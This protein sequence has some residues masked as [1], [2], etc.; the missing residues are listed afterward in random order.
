MK[1]T[2]SLILSSIVARR[3]KPYARDDELRHIVGRV[4]RFQLIPRFYDGIDSGAQVRQVGIYRIGLQTRHLAN[5][6]RDIPVRGEV[7]SAFIHLVQ[8]IK[9]SF[10][11]GQ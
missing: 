9:G 8:E 7:Q 10:Q 6:G 4:T 3:G 2:N 1:F 5:V 11:I